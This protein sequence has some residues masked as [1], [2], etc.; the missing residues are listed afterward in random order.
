MNLPGISKWN[1]NFYCNKFKFDI[2][3]DLTSG[4]CTQSFR[5]HHAFK[6]FLK[7]S[8]KK[9]LIPWFFFSPLFV[10]TET[11]DNDDK[12]NA[13]TSGFLYFQKFCFRSSLPVGISDDK[14]KLFFF[15]HLAAKSNFALFVKSSTSCTWQKNNILL[16]IL[17][18]FLL[19]RS[20]FLTS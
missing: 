6:T 9:F 17:P 7:S 12:E 13:F 15:F 8:K 4:I 18:L 14:R 20:I 1:E 3:L 5:S 16:I 10:R 2:G 11:C 19:Y